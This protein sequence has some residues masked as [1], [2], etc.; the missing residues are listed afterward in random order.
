MNNYISM[1]SLA[2]ADV[3]NFWDNIN[4]SDPIVIL[5]IALLAFSI[6]FPFFVFL[7]RS[8]HRK[9]RRRENWNLNRFVRISWL[10]GAFIF[11]AGFV[12]LILKIIGIM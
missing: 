5:S 11:I 8:I 3:V 7:I 6:I 4:L 12:I 2:R 1:R 10:L 9:I